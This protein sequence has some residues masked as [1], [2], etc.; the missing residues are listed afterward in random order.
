MES[1]VSKEEAISQDPQDLD[2][3]FWAVGH[4]DLPFSS[5]LEIA[6]AGGFTSLAVAASTFKQLAAQGFTADNLLEQAGERGLKFTQLDGLATW[7]HNWYPLSDNSDVTRGMRSHFDVSME[8]S[9]DIAQALQMTSAVTVG[10]FDKD[11]IAFDEIAG[12]FANLCDAAG[13]RGI[14][15]DLEIIPMWGIPE[16]PLAWDIV[17]AANR[18]NSGI[19]VDTWH[20]QKGSTDF[21]RDIALLETIPGNRLMNVQLAD[22]DLERHGSSFYDDVRFRKFAGEGE[23]DITRIL[24]IIASKGGLKSIGPEVIGHRLSGLTTAEVGCAAGRTTR[25]ALARVYELD[26]RPAMA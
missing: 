1:N 7:V 5:H 2:L 20:M 24:A 11:S 26:G 14:S 15:M 6:E 9:L 17:K 13:T 10:F 22:A 4:R 25:K 3:V 23:L 8:E 16:L 18:D 19:L 21:E 12:S